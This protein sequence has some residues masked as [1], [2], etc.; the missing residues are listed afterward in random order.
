MMPF[1]LLKFHENF[2]GKSM[3]LLNWEAKDRKNI[4]MRGSKLCMEKYRIVG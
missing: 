4:S 3:S 2:V 1:F